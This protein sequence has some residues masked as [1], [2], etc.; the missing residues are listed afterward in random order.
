MQPPMICGD[1]PPDCTNGALQAPRSR[2]AQHACQV[3]QTGSFAPEWSQVGRHHLR[4]SGAKDPREITKAHL[5]VLAMPFADWP[6]PYPACPSPIVNSI[7][8]CDFVTVAPPYVRHTIDAIL[9]KFKGDKRFRGQQSGFKLS[10]MHAGIH[11][12]M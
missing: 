7:A 1:F 12:Q 3:M 5:A 9:Q 4:A 11:H 8:G 2:N 6:T 10:Q